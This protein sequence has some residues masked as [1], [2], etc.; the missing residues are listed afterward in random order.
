MIKIILK[1]LI[2]KPDSVI[3]STNLTNNIIFDAIKA[4]ISRTEDKIT[5]ILSNTNILK[6]K[7]PN[8]TRPFKQYVTEVKPE[9][10]TDVDF[11]NF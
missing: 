10:N 8:N 1:I 6:K 11:R 9:I 4:E 2:K 5:D 3:N 7:G